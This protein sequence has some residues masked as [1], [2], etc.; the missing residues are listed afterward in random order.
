MAGK[1]PKKPA[2]VT[3][4]KA[5]AERLG[6]KR[7][8]LMC[9]LRLRKSIVASITTVHL[10]VRHGSSNRQTCSSAAVV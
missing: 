4:K 9:S 2:K 3:K 10:L 8:R 1:T 5:P 7:G 6:A